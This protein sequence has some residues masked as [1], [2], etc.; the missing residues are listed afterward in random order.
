VVVVR[1]R[2]PQTESATPYATL[3]SLVYFVQLTRGA[4]RLARGRMEGIEVFRFVPF[5]SS[6]YAVDILGY[7]F[8]SVANG[9]L[10]P[11]LVL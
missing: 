6:L 5:D 11:F 4:P 1:V 2:N 8:M 7:T 3:T 10:I 9:L